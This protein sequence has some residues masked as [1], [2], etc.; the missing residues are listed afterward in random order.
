M[1][2]GCLGS[3]KHRCHSCFQELAPASYGTSMT[4]KV[5][6]QFAPDDAVTCKSLERTDRL[7]REAFSREIVERTV[8][9]LQESD[10]LRATIHSQLDDLREIMAVLSDSLLVLL[11]GKMTA[12][13]RALDLGNISARQYRETLQKVIGQVLD[14]GADVYEESVLDGLRQLS[15]RL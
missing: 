3:V 7:G 14:E 8:V 11:D 6:T 4:R 15:A 12:C 9:V 5:T 2:S 10:G 13:L 1:N